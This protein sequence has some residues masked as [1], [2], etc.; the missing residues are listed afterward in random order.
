M[1]MHARTYSTVCN[2]VQERERVGRLYACP[3]CL[4]T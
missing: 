2:I 1:L 4:N 3:V